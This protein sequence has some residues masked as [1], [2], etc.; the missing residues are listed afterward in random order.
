MRYQCDSCGIEFEEP[1]IILREADGQEHEVEVCPNCEELKYREKAGYISQIGR[2]WTC[3]KCGR[4]FPRHTKV[5]APEG[6]MCEFCQ[7]LYGIKDS[8]DLLVEKYLPFLEKLEKKYDK[9]IEEYGE[10]EH[11]CKG[12]H[13][14]DGI[15]AHMWKGVGGE[16]KQAWSGWTMTMDSV[17]ISITHCPFCGEELK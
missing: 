11:D 16:I 8:V 10:P 4:V 12:K 13:F 9:L 5:P 6:T 14:G 1:R 3:A 15:A 17:T 7:Y 2:T